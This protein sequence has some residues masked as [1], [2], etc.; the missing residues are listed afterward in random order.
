MKAAKYIAWGYSGPRRVSIAGQTAYSA[1]GTSDDRNAG[2]S[3]V[4]L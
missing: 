4:L 3:R 2:K 1:G